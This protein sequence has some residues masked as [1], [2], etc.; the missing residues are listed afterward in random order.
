MREPLRRW[1]I[2]VCE[3]G[4]VHIHYGAGSLHILEEDFPE[5]AKA[6]LELAEQFQ[7]L[8]RSSAAHGKKEVLQ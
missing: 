2:A 3:R 7:L 6:I 8:A 4:T 5:M 1:Q